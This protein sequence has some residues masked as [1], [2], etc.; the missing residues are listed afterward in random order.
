MLGVIVCCGA[1]GFG[2]AARAQDALVEGRPVTEIHVVDDTGRDVANALPQLALQAGKPFD[3]VLER[4]SLRVLYHLGDYSDI[5]V[6]TN[7]E[8]SGVRVNFVVQ[9]NYYNNV[10]RI[11]GLKEPPTDSAALAAMRLSLGEPFRQSSLVEGIQRLQDTLRVDGLYL[12][13]VKWSLE[14][15]SDT[16]QMDVTV[17]VDPGPRARIGGFAVDNQTPY[18]DKQLLQHSKIKAKQE[19]TS[20]RL[21]HGTQKLKD[22]L[23]GQGY[24]GATVV[25]TPGSYDTQSNIVPLSYSVVAGPRVS[26]EITGAHLSKGQIRK[27]VPIYAEGGVDEDLLQEGRRNI[28]D[29]FQRQGY[30]NT[31]VQVRSRDAGN[32]LRVIGYDI[33]RGDR[34]RLAGVRFA[35]NKYFSTDLLTGRLQIQTASFASSGRFS[36]QLLRADIDSIR[37]LYISNG[38]R[39]V[40]VNTQTDDNYRGKKGNLFIT[41]NT[42]EGAQ[43]RVASLEIEGNKAIATDA[44]LAVVGSTRGQ[45]YSTEDVA[46]DRNNI[47]ALYYDDGFPKARFQEEVS[48]DAASGSAPTGAAQSD[49]VRIVYHISE[50]AR[51]EVA[52]VL[53]TGYQYTRPG[54]IARQVQV[55]PEG[56]LREGD[57]VDTQRR[58]YNLGVFTRVQIAPQNPDGTDPNKVVVVDAQEGHRYTIGYGF[59]FEVQ[60]IGAS[61]NT[62]STTTTCDPNATEIGSSPRVIFEIARSNMFGRAQTLSFR[63]RAS[64]LEYRAALGYTANN[65]LTNSNL[66]LQLTGF[67]EKTQDVTTFTS[68]RYEGALQLAQKVSPWSALLYRYFYRHVSAANLKVELEEVPLLSQPTLVSG[69]G[70]TYARDRRDNAGDPTRGTFN[71]ADVSVAATSLAS[72]ASFFRGFYQNSSYTTFGRAFVFAR[73]LRFGVEEPFGNTI[74]GNGPFNPA[75]CTTTQVAPDQ[76]VIPLPERFFAGGG[77]SLRGFGLNEAGPRDPC[78]G[79]PVGG[80]ALLVFNQELRFPMKLPFIGNRLGGTIFY[81]GGNVYTDL[82]HINFHWSPPSVTIPQGSSSFL[83]TE[84]NYFS[85]TVGFGF[86]YPTPV[87]PVRIDL[88]YQLNPA[89]YQFYNPT[90]QLFQNIRL[91]HFGFSFNIGP[92]F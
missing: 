58:L 90:T 65:F 45:P 33:S 40:Q 2:S 37:A 52:K 53:L 28:R 75:Q 73:S 36:Q 46:S 44:L 50:G 43:T 26:V 17:M 51:V 70:I 41:F 12:A 62:S 30:F 59:G 57:V 20:V 82:N 81:D 5:R 10:V 27:L 4:E 85:H 71:T 74:E 24:L 32:N 47:L 68:T 25:I 83:A 13:N 72:S 80:L 86:R 38:F 22:Y 56:P 48:P 3:F 60:R 76:E 42:V 69:F 23:V 15:H 21:S 39:D 88:G 67:A 19:L 16:R 89:L 7:V 91:P 6:T 49:R 35:G 87:G 1:A 54:I 14:P 78:T 55:K 29:Y 64:T 9:L 8:G 11:E 79:F 84:L 63:A 77:T 31:D 61:C 66:S 18:S 92:V 34:F